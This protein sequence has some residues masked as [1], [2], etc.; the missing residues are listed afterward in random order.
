MLQLWA[1]SKKKTFRQKFETF[2]WDHIWAKYTVD[3]GVCVFMSIISALIFAFGLSVFMTPNPTDKVELVSIVSGGSSGLSQTFEELITLINNGNQVT[4]GGLRLYTFIYIA[5]N[6]P[7]LVLAFKGI[8]I[9][10]AVC[11]LVN[12]G[13]VFLFSNLFNSN[14]EISKFLSH[15]GAFVADNGGLFSRALFAGV[16]TGLS[17]AIAF[18]FDTSAG[19][20]DIVSYYISLRKS[21]SVGKYGI[22]INAVIILSYSI[23]YGVSGKESSINFNGNIVTLNSWQMAFALAMFS[24]VYLITVMLI[25]DVINNRNKKVQVQI[26]TSIEELP[27]ML[28]AN[29]PHGATIVRGKGAYSGGDHLIIYMIVSSVELKEV[30]KV[31]RELDP[32]AFISVTALTQVYGRFYQ[33]PVK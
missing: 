5:I 31:A 27:K 19:G 32:T 7:L 12:V 14:P 13:A 16:C 1:M 30:L 29:I 18:K 15:I 4:I 25:I 33:R 20:F 11:T 23:I 24:A 17:S 26:I 6:A 9:R 10:F 28:I 8:G 2:C 22:L 3:W 21:T